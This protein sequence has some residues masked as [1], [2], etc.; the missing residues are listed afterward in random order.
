MGSKVNYY[1]YKII[2]C[3]PYLSENFFPKTFTLKFGN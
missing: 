2:I 1:D 3:V